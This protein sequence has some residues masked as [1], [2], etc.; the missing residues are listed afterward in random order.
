MGQG[1]V[2]SPTLFNIYNF[3]NDEISYLLYADDLTL[4]MHCVENRCKKWRMSVNHLTFKIVHFR[5]VCVPIT[6]CLIT[7]QNK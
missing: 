2:F 1:D 7:F 6:D 4:I 3:H 5:N